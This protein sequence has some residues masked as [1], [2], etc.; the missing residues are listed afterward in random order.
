ML[1]CSARQQ[2]KRYGLLASVRENAQIGRCRQRSRRGGKFVSPNVP[3][4]P[5]RTRNAIAIDGD[6][7]ERGAVIDGGAVGAQMQIE[8]R[9]VNELRAQ[10]HEVIRVSQL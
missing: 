9:E 8:P 7:V 1:L 6:R 4:G 3:G 5:L 2:V 10:V